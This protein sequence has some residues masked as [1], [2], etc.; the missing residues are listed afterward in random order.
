[1]PAPLLILGASVRA[2]ASSALR[3]GLVPVAVDLFADD[4]LA[5][6][7]PAR[8]VEPDRYPADLPII[9][10]ECPPGPWLY[11]GALE[12]H[13]EVIDR[14]AEDRP[15]WGVGGETLRR[16][17]DPI[18]LADALRRARLP[19]LDVALDPRG[20]PIDGSWLVKPIRSA[21]GAGIRPLAAGEEVP[22][23]RVYFQRFQPGQSGSALFIGQ[24]GEARLVGVTRQRVG[25]GGSPFGY[26]GSEGPITPPGSMGSQLDRTGSVLA[27]A[28]GLQ[29]L[30]GV[31]FVAEGGIAWPTEV[32]PRYT[33]SVEVIEYATGLSLLRDHA[34]AFG[35]EF[36]GHG[37][38]FEPGRQF[39]CKVVLFADRDGIVPASHRWPRFDP[40][41]AGPPPIADLPAPGSPFRAGQPVL[42][43]LERSPDA[44]ACRRRVARRR[45]RWQAILAGWSTGD[46]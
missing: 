36:E 17:R 24:G 31:D 35:A 11:T 33:A 7:C 32:N 30:F 3:A 45:G 6:T 27:G 20:L 9:A 23:G 19:A 5:A 16:V 43:L 4:D 34:R 14:I 1:M 29:G 13:P 22:P 8:R 41:S 39:A 10:A 44:R 46:G 12:N 15:L 25:R 37:T 38:C 26:V 21:A 2:S 40:R 18:A 28:F 42:T